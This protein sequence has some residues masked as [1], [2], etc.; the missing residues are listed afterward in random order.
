[1]ARKKNIKKWQYIVFLIIIAFSFIIKLYSYY[2]PKTQIVI[3]SEK[4]N[5]LLADTLEHR[6][7]GL[8][9]RKDFGKYNGM[10]FVFDTED[11]HAIVMRDMLF[12]IDIIWLD[13][14]K[15]VDM[16]PNVKAQP[17]VSESLLDY[18]LPRI[19]SDMVLELPAGFI[20]KYK[21][22]IGD[23]IVIME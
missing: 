20:G 23:S 22:K 6:Y 8:G 7:K 11:R 3:G 19:E 10:L 2:W 15:I 1:M 21:L 5:V 12:D 18:Y 13:D 4:I 17:N 9:K 14:L 16:A